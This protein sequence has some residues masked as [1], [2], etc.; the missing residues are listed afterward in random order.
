MLTVSVLCYSRVC[1]QI[2]P[3]LV[4]ETV[5]MAKSCSKNHHHEESWVGKFEGFPLSGEN[6]PLEDK[7]LLWL[8]PRISRF[9]PRELGLQSPTG[10]AHEAKPN[11]LLM[12]SMSSPADNQTRPREG[13]R[14]GL[15]T[16]HDSKR[17]YGNGAY[18]YVYQVVTF[19]LGR[20]IGCFTRDIHDFMTCSCSAT[21]RCDAMPCHAM[22]CHAMQRTATQGNARQRKATQ[23]NARQCNAR[24]RKAMQRTQYCYP[25]AHLTYV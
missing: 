1:T 7:N 20:N 24:Q 13:R 6:S 23:D 15:R 16:L 9:L 2:C 8:K 17:A 3:S 19:W 4:M 10:Q 12:A 5:G 22:S 18:E 21:M 14:E 11:A 25:I